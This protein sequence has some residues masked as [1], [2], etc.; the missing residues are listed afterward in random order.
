MFGTDDDIDI[1]G[2]PKPGPWTYSS[3]DLGIFSV[4]SRASLVGRVHKA[5]EA[6]VRA[7]ALAPGALLKLAKIEEIVSSV[8]SGGTEEA[9]KEIQRILSGSN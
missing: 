6:D 5:S 7:M 9:I 4:W 3:N 2:D 8:E 1:D